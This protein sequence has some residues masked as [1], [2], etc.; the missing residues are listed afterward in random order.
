MKTHCINPARKSSK[1]SE[2]IKNEIAPLA[3]MKFQSKLNLRD[4]YI[5]Q[6]LCMKWEFKH[7]NRKLSKIF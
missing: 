7:L 1:S 4:F 2:R 6:N 3:T 5:R